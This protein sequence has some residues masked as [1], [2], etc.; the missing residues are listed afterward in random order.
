MDGDER[1][2]TRQPRKQ[3]AA[4]ERRQRLAAALR[5]NLR[6]RKSQTRARAQAADPLPEP[7]QPTTAAPDQEDGYG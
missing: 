5:E 2:A 3:E 6:R 7:D 4:E 1:K